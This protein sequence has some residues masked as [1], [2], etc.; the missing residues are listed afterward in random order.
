[1]HFAIFS[2]ELVINPL[3]VAI[4][5]NGKK[6]LILDCRNINKNIAQFKFRFEN[7]IVT[8]NMLLENCKFFSF[9]L[10][11]AYH[12]I[13]IFDEHRKYLAFRWENKNYVFNV[14]PFGI[15]CAGHIFTKVC[16]VLIKK[17]RDSGYRVIMFLDDGLGIADSQEAAL[18]MVDN[19][20]NDLKSSGFL[21]AEDKCVREP[22]QNIKWLGLIWNSTENCLRISDSRIGD[23]LECL[24]CIL[25]ATSKGKLQFTARFWAAVIGKLISMSYV[26]GNFVYLKCRDMYGALLTRT[27]WNSNVIVNSKAIDEV[28]FWFKNLTTLNELPLFDTRPNA[29]IFSDASETGYGVFLTDVKPKFIKESRLRDIQDGTVSTKLPTKDTFKDLQSVLSGLACVEPDLT[30]LECIEPDLSGIVCIQPNLS[31]LE[32]VE[33][34]LSGSGNWK[35]NYLRDHNFGFGGVECDFGRA[36]ETDFIFKDFTCV[37]K[38]K[39]SEE[40]SDVWCPNEGKKSSTW[41]ELEA[42]FRIL[43]SNEN[44]LKNKIV[45]CYTDC[46]YI[47]YIL[48][49]GSPIAE[50]HILALKKFTNCACKIIVSYV[51]IGFLDI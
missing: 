41:R 47:V 7:Y 2:G 23:L 20:R 37:D 3:T 30:G 18:I 35:Y 11:S 48:N 19:I 5:K 26:I 51:C 14:L 4:Q 21:V 1:M 27:S 32:S 24:K 44:L 17:W 9:D 29:Y 16:R 40:I 38:A 31:G 13:E 22:T 43:K 12:H 50:L 8:H 46:R 42:V 25:V 39:N 33:P 6:R 49:K 15:S 36:A 45:N 10:K 28:E 34:D